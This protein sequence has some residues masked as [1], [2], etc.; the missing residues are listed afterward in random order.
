MSSPTPI[1]RR[2]TPSTSPPTCPSALHLACTHRRGDPHIDHETPPP[3]YRSPPSSLA[4]FALTWTPSASTSTPSCGTASLS[5]LSS[6][7]LRLTRKVRGPL[8]GLG[9]SVAFISRHPLSIL[10]RVC[11]G[12]V[13]RHPDGQAT[14]IFQEQAA[15]VRPPQTGAPNHASLCLRPSTSIRQPAGIFPTSG[16]PLP[17]VFITATRS[18]CTHPS[19]DLTPPVFP[20]FPLSRPAPAHR[21][22][23]RQPVRRSASAGLHGPCSSSPFPNLGSGRSHSLGR[24]A[25]RLAH[26]GA[27][28]DRN[29]TPPHIIGMDRLRSRT[30]PE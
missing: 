5:A 9:G 20:P 4:L 28:G 15:L 29:I 3:L 6:P 7:S 27:R 11:R 17:P 23:G 13:P 16:W 10:F 18:A 19:P 14:G 2:G 26:P 30:S 25:Y 22:Q 1:S 12:P 21:R 8:P 24:H